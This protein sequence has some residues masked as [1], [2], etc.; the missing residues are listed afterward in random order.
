MR[1]TGNNILIAPLPKKARSKGGIHLLASYNDDAKQFVVL[2]VG[3]GR[4]VRK[5]GKEPVLIS[6]EVD[7]GDHVLA[8]LYGGNKMAFEDGSGRLVVDASEVLAK[9]RPTV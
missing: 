2:E 9:W 5:K 3:P 8:N 7:P 1:M 4:T 6:P